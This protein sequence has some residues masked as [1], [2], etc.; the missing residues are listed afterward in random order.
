MA[1]CCA[2]VGFSLQR[3]NAVTR[4]HPLPNQ[5]LAAAL[6]QVLFFE[7]HEWNAKFIKVAA[8]SSSFF[9]MER[10]RRKEKMCNTKS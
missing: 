10:E 1:A 5:M 2:R 4:D 7:N 3:T 6:F 8:I 9:F